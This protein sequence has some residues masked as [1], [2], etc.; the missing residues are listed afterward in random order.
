MSF[1]DLIK[2]LTLKMGITKTE[3]VIGDKSAAKQKITES[4]IGQ[5]AGRDILNQ[6]A[7]DE[8]HPF[9]EISRGTTVSSQGR[10]EAH[11]YFR[12]V[13]DSAGTIQSFSLG[14]QDIQIE[15]KTLTPN[16][17]PYEIQRDLTDSV[18]RNSRLDDPRAEVI[19][20]S[21]GGK[22]Y[23]TSAKIVQG[24]MKVPTFNIDAI[25]DNEFI[26]LEDIQA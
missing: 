10:Y 8:R 26:Q 12:N 22:V 11:F 23:K 17:R 6:R 5:V 25:E 15:R 7:P 13:G 19:Y 14:G 9:I 1:I 3:K 21:L 4:N 2:S 16:D 20:K 24:E 18:I